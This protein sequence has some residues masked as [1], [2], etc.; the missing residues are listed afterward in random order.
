MV[1]SKNVKRGYIT[2]FLAKATKIL[3]PHQA[4][5]QI[6]EH[7]EYSLKCFEV[8]QCTAKTQDVRYLKEVKGYA[9][10]PYS[11]LSGQQR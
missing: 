8:A 11:H 5:L 3:Y 2:A 10:L 7:A 1:I 6:S 4:S 9:V